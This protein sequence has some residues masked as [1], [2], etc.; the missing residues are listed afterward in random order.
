MNSLRKIIGVFIM[1][2]FALPLLFG[3]IWAVGTT[4]AVVSPEFLSDMPREII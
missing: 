1:L 4:K 2:F 3:I